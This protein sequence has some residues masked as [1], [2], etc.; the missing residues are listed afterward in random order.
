[1]EPEEVIP[2]ADNGSLCA[3]SCMSTI[4]RFRFFSKK[5]K[6]VRLIDKDGIIRLQRKNGMIY[7]CEGGK[8][9]SAIQ[10]ILAEMTVFGDGGQEMPNVYIACGSRIIDLSS[11]QSAKQM[12]ALCEIEFSGI[13]PDEKLILIAT[14]TTE[15]ERG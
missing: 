4:T 2:E 14:R 3:F 11:M 12:Y 5:I 9:K 8:W 10:T 1:V 13:E 6:S 7:T 15:N